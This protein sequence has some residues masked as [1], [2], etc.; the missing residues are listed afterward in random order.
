MLLSDED[1]IRLVTLVV[2]ETLSAGSAAVELLG[3]HL[4]IDMADWWEADEAFLE[5]L[6]D[7]AI[8]LEL[9]EEVTGKLVADA[10]RQEKTKVLKQI[11]R[12][13]LAGTDGRSR[14][15]PWVPRWMRFSPA[16]YTDRGGVA[17]VIA[18]I[19]AVK[20][21]AE[22]Q[23]DEA[24]ESRDPVDEAASEGGATDDGEIAQPVAAELDAGD[25]AAE[26]EEEQRFAA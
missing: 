4:N 18:H 16:A 1:I 8:L 9:V 23:A 14:T 26:T 17:T 20:E 6:R 7:R 5:P 22:P 15:E 2:G 25:V 24:E 11:I 19:C 10:N 21:D 12:D 13:Y 3:L